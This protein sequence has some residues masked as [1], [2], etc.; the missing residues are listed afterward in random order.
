MIS[1]DDVRIRDISTWF[2]IPGLLCGLMTR[3]MKKSNIPYVYH[4]WKQ[5]PE[6]Q[7]TNQQYY[8]KK[9]EDNGYTDT[10]CMNAIE[11]TANTDDL[12]QKSLLFFGDTIDPDYKEQEEYCA[13]L[14][15]QDMLQEVDAIEREERTMPNIWLE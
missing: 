10:F 8:R 11:T 1:F 7:K 4:N 13:K 12:F 5:I 14:R 15:H 6:E 9:F 2:F 3:E